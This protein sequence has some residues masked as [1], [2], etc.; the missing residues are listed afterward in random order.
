MAAP[1]ALAKRCRSP[2]SCYHRCM[3]MSLADMSLRRRLSGRVASLP[4]AAKTNI[5]LYALLTAMAATF[6]L[7]PRMRAYL[8]GRDGWMN[9]GIGV[10]TR[11]DSVRQ[12]IHFEGGRARVRLGIPTDIDTVL[13]FKDESVVL[14]MLEITP[15]EVM[16]LLLKSEMSTEGN[17][18]TLSKFNFLLSVVLRDRHRA[19]R[20][21]RRSQKHAQREADIA[22]ETET[23]PPRTPGSGVTS[24]GLRGSPCDEVKH[25]EDPYLSDYAIDDFPRLKRFLDLHFT[26]KPAICHER[27]LLVTEWCRE[28]GFERQSN[29]E[30]W[31]PELRQ[32]KLFKHLMESRRPIIREGDLIAGTTTTQEIG[33][34]LYPDTH[35]TM[36]WGELFS[37]PDREL[38]PYD[39]AQDTR[40]I[41]H[42]DVFPYWE[43]RNIREWVR[44]EHGGL[45]GQALDERFAVYF[46]WKTVA[47]SHTIADFP[48]LLRLG[49]SGMIEELRKEQEATP[50]QQRDK[51]NLLEAMVLVLE[52]MT[53]YAD[54]LS[55]QAALDAEVEVDPERKRELEE[56]CRICAKVPRF[57]SESVHEALNAIWIVW[58]GLHMENTNAGLSL[59]RMD[60]W[61]Q[62][63]FLA[64]VARLETADAVTRYVERVIELVGC[65]YMRCTDHLP[66]VPDIGNFLFGGSSSDQAITLGGMTPRGENA[67]ND[68]TYIFLK[69]TEMLGIRDPNVNAR[70][71]AEVNSES[72]MKRLCEVNLITTATPSLHNDRAVMAALAEF[73]YPA[74]H[75]RDWAATGCVEPTLSGRHMGH[76]GNIMFNMV[77]PL[78]MAL[79]DGRHP[80]MDWKVGPSTGEDFASFEDFFASFEKQ[81]GFLVDQMCEYN[82]RLGEAHALLRPT[83][84]LSSLIE[85][86]LQSGLDVTKGGA[87]YN[88]TGVACIGLSDVTDSLMTIKRLVF[89]KGVITFDELKR[90]L[91]NNFE[92]HPLVHT[93]IQKKVPKFGSGDEEALAMANRVAGFAHDCLAA[94]RNYRGAKYTAGFWSMSNHVAFGCLS[95]ALPSGR[96]AGRPFTPGLT[97][98]PSASK[99]LL[100][101]IRDVA[102]LDPANMTNNIAFNVKVTPGASDTHAQAVDNIQA[103]AKSYFDLGGMQMQFNVVTSAHLRDAML[104]P[105]LHRHLLVRISGYNAYFV[106]LNREMQLELVDRA[107]YQV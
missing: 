16:D 84:L 67:V 85:G 91:A 45:L 26:K 66:L 94:H 78:E 93:L 89:E 76:T 40:E 77:A 104:H 59:G 46:I 98:H 80:L 96:V 32:A 61:L 106:T 34:V 19:M 6:R 50:E 37:A 56:L 14:K 95:G 39:I 75:L 29:G 41:L 23:L 107:D 100:D 88:T 103:Y 69:V 86:S 65:F 54:R 87:R 102:R 15:E 68:M 71:N 7:R 62:P 2:R 97:P 4:A 92:S 74:E 73:D 105:E 8:R 20:E 99:T 35:A 57:P 43:K 12:S 25:L 58:V 28:H 33:V 48:K 52:G 18:A 47:I 11:D 82:D 49:T 64:D 63:Y 3:S 55:R 27:A 31:V 38:N 90:A 42:F 83:P 72:Y 53:S 81:F 30:P 36:I 5:I 79:N 9:F 51:R 24:R 17:L 60:Q 10:R 101:P 44:R 21:A 22:A 1:R 70:F 13:C